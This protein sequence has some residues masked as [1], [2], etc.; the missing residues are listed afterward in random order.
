[1]ATEFVQSLSGTTCVTAGF[2]ELFCPDTAYCTEPVAFGLVNASTV[3][4]YEVSVSW[5]IIESTNNPPCG[6]FA[7]V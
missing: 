7:T 5:I 2:D 3:P 1:L 6:R 4:A